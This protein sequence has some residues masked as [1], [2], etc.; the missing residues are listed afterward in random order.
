MLDNRIQKAISGQ[1]Y[2]I[3][4]FKTLAQAIE[5]RNSCKYRVPVVLGN[6]D[7]FWV[8]PNNKWV[9]RL[10]DMGYELA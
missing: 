6:D 1:S 4:R 7:K 8:C 2:A 10:I 5:Y 3:S 9:G